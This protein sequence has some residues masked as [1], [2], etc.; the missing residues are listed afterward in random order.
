MT[1][2]DTI[3]CSDI[4]FLQGQFGEDATL[5]EIVSKLKEHRP[6]VCPQC[7]GKGTILNRRP[8]PNEMGGGDWGYIEEVENC[9]LCD[10]TGRT[11]VRYV[12]EMKQV[13]WK[14]E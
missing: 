9:S 5:S 6:F 13:G 2:L 8:H 10:G 14:A 11:K 4:E 1:S 12:P 3:R 7:K